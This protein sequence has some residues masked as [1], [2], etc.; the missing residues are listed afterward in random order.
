MV[1]AKGQAVGAS[2]NSRPEA[3][4][5]VTL[6]GMLWTGCENLLGVMM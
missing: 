2:H 6:V 5:C 3:V 1:F 4:R